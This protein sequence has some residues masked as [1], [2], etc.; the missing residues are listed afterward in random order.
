MSRSDRQA[1]GR[2]LTSAPIT[3]SAGI[4][5]A[6]FSERGLAELDFPNRASRSSNSTEESGAPYHDWLLLTTEAVTA[7][8][9]GQEPTAFPP[10]DLSVGS[11]FKQ[12]VWL[13]LRGIR[14]GETKTYG[15]I[16]REVGEPE[17][18]RAVGS[19]CGA[20]PIPLL[21]PCHRV[22]ASGGKL[23]GF[24]GG[25]EWKKRLLAIEGVRARAGELPW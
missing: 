22:V 13:A 12:R 7:I 19:A 17:A 2:A 11:A 23:G 18:T 10:L 20:N 21:V 3:T 16:A 25:L 9:S 5:T 24:S 8:L 6:H 1:S 14:K 15:E 4:F